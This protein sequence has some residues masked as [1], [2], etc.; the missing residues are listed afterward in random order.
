MSTAGT[1]GGSTY[2]RG[3]GSFVKVV[4]KRRKK[5]VEGNEGPEGKATTM[6]SL[7]PSAC[8]PDSVESVNHLAKKRVMRDSQESSGF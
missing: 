8:N 1:G 6:K 3:D 7:F 2:S 4:E 5:S